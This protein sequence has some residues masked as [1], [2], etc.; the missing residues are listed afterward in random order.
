MSEYVGSI[1]LTNFQKH[2]K[3]KLELSPG[4]NVVIGESNRGKSS[5]NRAFARLCANSPTGATCVRFGKTK[6]SVEICIVGESSERTVRYTKSKTNGTSYTLD[7]SDYKRCG[8][9]VPEEIRDTL[10]IV[11]EINI[12]PQHRQFFLL[13]GKSAQER[14]K[15]LARGT[16]IDIIGYVVA[17]ARKQCYQ[18]ESSQKAKAAEAAEARQSLTALKPLRTAEALTEQAKLAVSKLRT[19]VD[20]LDTLKSLGE[21]LIK[22]ECIEKQLSLLPTS[23]SLSSIFTELQAKT[24]HLRLLEEQKKLLQVPDATVEVTRALS[25]LTK[26]SAQ[27]DSVHAML[28]EVMYL[29]K[30]LDGWLE[31][32]TNTQKE[33]AEYRKQVGKLCKTCGRPI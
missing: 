4:I 14:A 20:C 9:T 13:D 5:I 28:V 6:A 7:Q 12:Q 17:E 33:I 16:N 31:A 19:C 1:E 25:E 29:K 24:T 26:L 8:R 11:P 2:R 32:E 22:I 30:V 10:R 27:L 21:R 23:Y 3:L 15:Q 18:F